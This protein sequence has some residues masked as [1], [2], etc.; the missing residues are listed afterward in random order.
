MGKVLSKSEAALLD[1]VRND[2]LEE[3]ASM[4]ESLPLD[5]LANAATLIRALKYDP[6]RPSKTSHDRYK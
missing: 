5:Q 1:G 4:V 6:I 3:A 2:A